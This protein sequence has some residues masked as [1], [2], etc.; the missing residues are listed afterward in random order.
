MLVWR[1]RR[2][3]AMRMPDLIARRHRSFKTMVMHIDDP[4]KSQV[5]VLPATPTRRN[6]SRPRLPGRLTLGSRSGMAKEVK[7]DA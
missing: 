7:P 5:A 4:H 3:R 2:N 6:G 1:K